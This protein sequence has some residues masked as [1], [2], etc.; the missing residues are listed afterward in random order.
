MR[1]T[2]DVSRVCGPLLRSLREAQ[3]DVSMWT[4]DRL[5]VLE[6]MEPHAALRHMMRVTLSNEDKRMALETKNAL[7]VVTTAPYTTPMPSPTFL[8]LSPEIKMCVLNIVVASNGY[9]RHEHFEHPAVLEPMIRMRPGTV[10]HALLDILRNAFV[11]STMQY[12]SIYIISQ[13]HFHMNRLS[14]RN[15]D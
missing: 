2:E 7:D 6:D 10:M 4:L 15:L 14:Q 5:K 8:S 9:V 11:F 13:L 1:A 3:F 12:P